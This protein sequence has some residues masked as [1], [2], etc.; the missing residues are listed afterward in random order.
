MNCY[1]LAIFLT[2]P[3]FQYFIYIIIFYP[4]G[5]LHVYMIIHMLYAEYFTVKSMFQIWFFKEHRFGV[6]HLKKKLINQYCRFHG[7]AVGIEMR[8]RG[9]LFKEPVTG[10]KF[11]AQNGIQSK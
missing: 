6:S 10:P 9:Q 4:E 8:E 7:K 5:V 3:H 2:N 11:E 1:L